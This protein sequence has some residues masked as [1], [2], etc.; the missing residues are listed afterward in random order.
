MIRWN[1]KWNM[2]ALSEDPGW[3]SATMLVVCNLDADDDLGGLFGTSA[4]LVFSIVNSI[5]CIL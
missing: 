1:D 2:I 5:P 3:D 4:P